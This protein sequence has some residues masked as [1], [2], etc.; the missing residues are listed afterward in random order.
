MTHETDDGKLVD[1]LKWVT[2]ELHSTRARLADVESGGAEPVAVVG[3]ACRYPGGVASPDDLWRLVADGGDAIGG[4]PA[5]RGWDLDGLFDPDPDHPGTSY[6]R[7]GGFLHDA[8]AFD[9]AFFGISPREALAMDPQQRLLLEVAWETFERAGIVPADLRGSATGVFAGVIYADYAAR[10]G[11]APAEVEGFLGSGSAASVASG[12]VAYTFGLEGPAVTV[13]TAC[14]SSLV[15]VHLAAHALRR[16]ECSLALAGGVTV[17]STPGVFVEFSRQRGMSPDGRCRSFATSADGTGWSEGAGLVLLERL[18]DARR[19]G[20]R[21]LALVRGSAINQDGA[22]N[23][24]TAP[25]GP[26]QER[27]IHRA[28]AEAGLTTNDIDAVEA[29]GTGTTLGDPIEAQALINT[30]GQQRDPDK[31]LWLG[32][33]KSN[34]GHTQAAAGT[35][36]IIKMIMGIRHRTLPR[37]LHVDAPTPH[38]DW[39]DSGVRLLTEARPWPETESPR[40]AAVSSFGISGTNAH[41]ILEQ[42]PDEQEPEQDTDDG[43][44]ASRVVPWTLSA[45]TPGALRGQAERLLGFVRA[46]DA[47]G[48]RAVG[49]ALATTRTAFEHRA[50]VVAADQDEATRALAALARDEPSPNVARYRAARPPGATAFLFSG[51]GSQRAGMGRDLY[52]D[53]PV[54]AEALDEACAEFAGHLDEPLRETMFAPPRSPR[55][56]LLDQTLYTQPALFAYQ[57]ALHRLITSFGIVPTHLL[58]HSIGELTAA[59]LAGVLSLRDAAA[60]IAA[61]ARL[62]QDAGDGVM[63][64]VNASEDA[65]RALLD[66]H[67]DRVSIAAVNTPDSVVLSGD[68]DTALEL[69]GRLAEQGLRTRRVNV[70]NAFHS[71][72]MDPVLEDFRAVADA[73]AFQ[74]PTIPVVSNVTGAIGGA[75]FT[76]PGYWAR[77]LRGTVR[78]ADGITTLR[79]EGVTTFVELGPD[80]VLSA[81]VRRGRSES[82][83]GAIP[84]QRAGRPEARTFLTALAALDA[85]GSPV[86]WSAAF[87]PGPVAA[88]LPTYAFERD[89]YWLRADAPAAAPPDD[90][91]PDPA[92]WAAVDRGDL[93]ALTA[94]LEAEPHEELAIGAL[95]P[96]LARWR[97][98]RR[99]RY[100]TVWR[101]V[102]DG[103]TRGTPGRWAVLVPDEVDAAS[104]EPLLDA[105]RAEGLDVVPLPFRT[106]EAAP[107]GPIPDRI[108]G[109]LALLA[110]DDGAP[111]RAAE[112]VRAVAGVDVPVW[113][114]TRRAVAARPADPPPD[115]SRAA[116]W[117]LGEALAAE[118]PGRVGLADLPD[119]PDAGPPAAFARTLRAGADRDQLAFRE[120]GVFARR[121]TRAA[122]P[123]GLAPRGDGTVLV[124]APRGVDE[125]LVARAGAGAARTVVAAPPELGA[126]ETTDWD[127]ADASGLRSLLAA[128][129]ADRP[130]ARVVFDAAAPASVE[131]DGAAAPTYG[132]FAAELKALVKAALEI[133]ALTRADEPPLL[134]FRTRSGALLPVPGRP[135]DAVARAFL[136][137]VA[138]ARRAAGF[139]AASVAWDPGVDVPGVAAALGAE[140]EPPLLLADTDWDAV[141]GPVPPL[142][143]ELRSAPDTAPEDASGA[144][145]GGTGPDWR[146]LVAAAPADERERLLATLVRTHAAAALGHASPEAIEPDADL[147][148]L[149]IT[150]FSA[151]ELRNL[152][153]EATGVALPATVVFEEPTL[154]RLA[155]RLRAGLDG[156]AESDLERSI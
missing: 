99:T 14:S 3:M 153:A 9:P 90:G 97:R 138:A 119:G 144:R 50:V 100:R 91:G 128:I 149:G 127:P 108:A 53:F 19:N 82:D 131:P 101:P 74:R 5:G 73:L 87:G 156:A 130:L 64:A 125:D 139:P 59:H 140:A 10:L 44:A 34:L 16:G 126:G 152:L 49:R 6:S 84:V 36:G 124:L 67:G 55:A 60:L 69:A 71:P 43:D 70:S 134:V 27:L 61:R 103:P 72:H 83:A 41:V 155:A 96:A 51:Q 75:E 116:L 37:T 26:S 122:P 45:R 76:D 22:S 7:E 4:F 85:A 104:A 107:S 143:D 39:D 114:A 62:M 150:S 102:A 30:Y 147:A 154:S 79:A 17:M 8:D 118:R 56:T 106:G 47:P 40:R 29:H 142:F 123:S 24:L 1:Y 32:S 57:T 146:E 78:F 68:A 137:A 105:L 52:E 86:A 15:A 25:N 35:A 115:P 133:D 111:K 54:F 81:M 129:P 66:G 88:D 132:D 33:I 28:L 65:V 21:V 92:F 46:E 145:D 18:S 77:H 93:D 63:I 109:V 151:L 13:D 95:V 38:V 80:A 2:A 23:G 89:R 48:P 31:P 110:F 20:H 94:A 42:P 148:E 141:A 58:G 117:G 135:A 136:D 12:R 11:R 112:L 98:G 120:S 121:L 113:L